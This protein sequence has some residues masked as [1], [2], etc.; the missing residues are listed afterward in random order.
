MSSKAA[1]ISF[2]VWDP[3]QWMQMYFVPAVFERFA[4]KNFF[5]PSAF[6]AHVFHELNCLA[7]F[8]TG[9]DIVA[10]YREMMLDHNTDPEF[11]TIHRSRR[12][13]QLH[14]W[15]ITRHILERRLQQKFYQLAHSTWLKNITSSI[16]RRVVD[17]EKGSRLLKCATTPFVVMAKYM[18]WVRG[19]GFSS[20]CYS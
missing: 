18:P 15:K 19:C 20:S 2:N 12:R 13:R 1:V 9:P 4:C 16:L 17:E 11:T 6:P 8:L 3:I 7:K 5:S 14:Q 10:M